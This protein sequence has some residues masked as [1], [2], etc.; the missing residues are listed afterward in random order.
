MAGLA[1]HRREGLLLAVAVGV[2]GVTFGVLA[3]AAGLTLAQI[4]VMSALVFTGA[5]QFA[6]VS[7]V[8]AGGSG[9]AAVGSAMLLAARNALYGPVVDPVLPRSRG[10]RL[11]A[12]QLVIDETTAMASVQ[13]DPADAADAFWW[14]GIWLWS[15]WNLG[16]VG[17]AQLGSVI[18]DPETW[19]LDAAFPAAFVALLAPHLR[20]APGR[21]AAGLGAVVAVGAVPFVAAGVPLLLAALAV[22]PAAWL[23]FRR[24]S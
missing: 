22:V 19:G 7:V 21:V 20:T 15:L 10:R 11:V 5:S 9:A 4:V 12:T 6:A 3:D 23:H 14:T 18:G 13:E 24:S 16:S 2:V 1:P 17:G 8:D